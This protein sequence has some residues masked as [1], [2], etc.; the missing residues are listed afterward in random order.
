MSM[1]HISIA[2]LCAQ[3]KQGT[4]YSKQYSYCL[5][6]SSAIVP[7][8]FTHGIYTNASISLVSLQLQ[9]PNACRELVWLQG[10]SEH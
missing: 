9:N 1:S 5:V 3:E 10:N 7:S 4:N 8:T 2:H 6:N